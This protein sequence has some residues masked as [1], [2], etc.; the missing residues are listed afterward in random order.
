MAFAPEGSSDG[1]ARW[2]DARATR[3]TKAGEAEALNS[4][5]RTSNWVGQDAPQ[6]LFSAGS[7]PHPRALLYSNQQTTVSP[8]L[9][10]TSFIHTE[11]QR[12]QRQ[13]KHASS[14]DNVSYP[15]QIICHLSNR[16]SST[17]SDLS[18]SWLLINQCVVVVLGLEIRDVWLE[19]ERQTDSTF[20][21]RL[22][23]CQTSSRVSAVVVSVSGEWSAPPASPRTTG[24]G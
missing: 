19:L 23:I 13:H 6:P 3:S 22:R 24:H 5:I 21:D 17:P 7:L 16:R 4:L 8:S 2:L 1:T 15:Y 20:L 10:F 11:R 12:P 14:R 9:S 18:G